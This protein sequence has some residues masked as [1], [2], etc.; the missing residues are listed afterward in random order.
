MFPFQSMS[1]VSRASVKFGPAP[2]RSLFPLAH[3][4]LDSAARCFSRRRLVALP[5]GRQFLKVAHIDPRPSVS[6]RPRPSSHA[7]ML[8]NTSMTFRTIHCCHLHA[9]RPTSVQLRQT[10]KTKWP[11]AGQMG[12]D[13]PPKTMRL[14]D[15]VSQRRAFSPNPPGLSL[16]GATF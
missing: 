8:T 16:T 9:D 12:P 13:R 2:S 14:I 5:H 3:C 1:T 4:L 10:E 6:D 15:E 7:A 11:R